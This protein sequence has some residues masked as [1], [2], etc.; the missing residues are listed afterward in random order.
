MNVQKVCV[1]KFGKS[2]VTHVVVIKWW[3]ELF[4]RLPTRLR[5]PQKTHT[6]KVHTH[7]QPHTGASKSQT[8]PTPQ[9]L[10]TIMLWSCSFFLGHL[11]THQSDRRARQ[12]FPTLFCFGSLQFFSL[13]VRR[14][15]RGISLGLR[16]SR[17]GG[18]FVSIYPQHIRHG[19]SRHRT[20]LTRTHTQTAAAAAHRPLG[21]A[22][23]GQKVR[24]LL[25]GRGQEGVL[26]PQLGAQVPVRGPQG[27]KDGLDEVP[28]GP[29][30]AACA[31]VAVGD[32]CHVE[33]LLS[34]GGGDQARPAGSGD[35][36]DADRSAL[37]GDLARDGVGEAGR[38]A[39]VPPAD[40][41]DVELGGGNGTPNG[42]GDLGGALDAQPDV[43]RG[44]P[45][46]HEGLEA[47]ALAGAGL[48][49]HRHDLHDLVLELVLEEVVDD[50]RLLDGDG[51]E[52]DLL[53]AA[54]LPLLHQTAELGDGDPDVL[55]PAGP[56]SAAPSTASTAA[57]ASSS[58]AAEASSSAAPLSVASGGWSL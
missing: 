3:N 13:D 43:A 46:R 40:G 5:V 36:A 6:K 22:L 32:A 50:L 17:G 55:V 45:D 42:S 29:G 41:G 18:G 21:D 9:T 27:V 15:E 4:G 7:H 25:E 51:E 44:V 16:L 49:L 58:A 34:R 12:E 2:R 26:G 31:G 11:E 19:V 33:E 35:E 20:L 1:V 24:V 30:V 8:L 23:L 56:A 10:Y 47:G 37:A 39:P 48:L 38:S 57:A 28:H 52:E 54:D 53:N 14:K